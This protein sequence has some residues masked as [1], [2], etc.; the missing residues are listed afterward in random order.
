MDVLW[1]SGLI[2]TSKEPGF[3]HRWTNS[4]QW[5]KKSF[6][7]RRGLAPNASEPWGNANKMLLNNC[8][9]QKKRCFD[10]KI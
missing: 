9:K 2:M 4:Q 3:E 6:G 5:V 8:H 1:Y 10:M 7:N